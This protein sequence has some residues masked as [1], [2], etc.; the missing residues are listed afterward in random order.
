MFFDQ[1]MWAILGVSAFIGAA[2]YLGAAIRV[3]LIRPQETDSTCDP[4]S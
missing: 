4:L 1:E 3:G 2:F